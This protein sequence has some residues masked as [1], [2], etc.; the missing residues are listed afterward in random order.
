M[1]P[2]RRK[3]HGGLL[4]AGWER[5]EQVDAGQLFEFGQTDDRIDG[6]GGILD[7]IGGG[8]PALRV[9][10]R[11]K[12][13]GGHQDPA[14]ELLQRA[15]SKQ[16]T[17]N[18]IELAALFGERP[19]GRFDPFPEVAVIV[20]VLRDHVGKREALLLGLRGGHIG[21]GGHMAAIEAGPGVVAKLRAVA[22]WEPIFWVEAVDAGKVAG[23]DQMVPGEMFS[24]PQGC[25]AETGVHD[26]EGHVAGLAG[27]GGQAGIRDLRS[28][29][30]GVVRGAGGGGR[31]GGRS[32]RDGGEEGQQEDEGTRRAP[33]SLVTSHG[34][35]YRRCARTVQAQNGLTK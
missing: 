9:V 16:G 30:A 15:A 11:L 3:R 1:G 34:E 17:R 24:R 6:C 19:D 18:D 33:W 22:R 8:V 29:A 28:L 26:A 13:M 10:D 25:P 14:V 20:G 4:H 12:E 32:R 23:L 35:D 2:W 27:L 31:E 5:R 21:R 7:Q